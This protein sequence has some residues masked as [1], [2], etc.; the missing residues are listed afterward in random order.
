ML[1]RAN[2]FIAVFLYLF[3]NLA[4]AQ[5]DSAL[6]KLGK[7][8]EAIVP[9]L[10]AEQKERKAEEDARRQ[11]ERMREEK[12]DIERED[13]LAQ[14]KNEFQVASKAALERAEK[15]N[16]KREP[17]PP[18][19]REESAFVQEM[20]ARDKTSDPASKQ[21]SNPSASDET[22]RV[23]PAGKPLPT[24]AQVYRASYDAYQAGDLPLAKKGFETGLRMQPDPYA[25]YYLIRVYERMGLEEDALRLVGV[26][27]KKYGQSAPFLAAP[28]KR[29]Q[30]AKQVRDLH[31]FEN[32]ELLRLP[33]ELAERIS[34]S[35]L[36]F[37]PTK[38]GFSKKIDVTISQ[39]DVKST[40][41]GWKTAGENG[42]VIKTTSI[43]TR[44]PGQEPIVRN[45]KEFSAMGGMVDVGILDDS[46]PA[47]VHL[48][49]IVANT[50]PAFMAPGDRIVIISTWRGEG[51][52]YSA[53]R[54][55]CDAAE[56]VQASTIERSLEG[57]ALPLKCQANLD[58]GMRLDQATW[59]YLEAYGMV[60][61]DK[62]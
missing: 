27:G 21:L 11:V 50:S 17:L 41:S 42:L 6:E 55:E 33:P 12:A 10:E 30:A 54:T 38:S 18:W 39:G 43:T 5:S 16:A 62:E 34:T 36:F 26:Y 9:K 37:T 61:T 45:E 59:N 46:A 48:D 49:S 15:I 4:Q 56:W 3:S 14:A 1:C 28:E 53:S 35:S 57:K 31:W 40:I 2:F 60:L 7:G 13:K 25:A 24:P 44:Q 29:L 51:D 47:H 8:L 58:N 23:T 19:L 32:V 20:E 52:G 22:R